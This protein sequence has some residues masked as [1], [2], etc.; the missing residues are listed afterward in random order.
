MKPKSSP[1]GDLPPEVS[2]QSSVSR[3]ARLV[4]ECFFYFRIANC[5]AGGELIETNIQSAH[6]PQKAWIQSHD[7]PQTHLGAEPW[8]NVVKTLY[9]PE[10]GAGWSAVRPE[11]QAVYVDDRVVAM[12]SSLGGSPERLRF[13]VSTNKYPLVLTN[14][15][16]VMDAEFVGFTNS[17]LRFLYGDQYDVRL[18]K[19]LGSATFR[20]Y[21][22]TNMWGGQFVFSNVTR[23]SKFKGLTVEGTNAVVSLEIGTNIVARIGFNKDVMPVWAT[24]NGVS[25]GPIPTNCVF[26]SD[27]VS[28]KVVTKVVY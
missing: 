3:L 18:E 1:E 26:Y 12:Y 11:Y 16:S 23:P 6:G 27:V 17:A 28:N 2:R 9:I 24:T 5:L 8:T 15:S 7:W 22:D 10:T 14:L 19:L 21:Y 4:A 20:D 13:S 25:I